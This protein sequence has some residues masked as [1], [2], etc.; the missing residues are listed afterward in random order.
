M[1]TAVFLINPRHPARFTGLFPKQRLIIVLGQSGQLLQKGAPER[2]PGGKGRLAGLGYPAIPGAHILADV[3]AKDQIPVAATQLLGNIFFYFDRQVGDAAAAVHDVGFHNGLGRALVQ[4]AAAASAVIAPRCIRVEFPVEQ[5]LA[6][7]K[8]GAQLLARNQIGILADPSDPGA[9]R[10]V[11]VHHRPRVH[12]DP[13]RGAGT[14][15]LNRLHQSFQFAAQNLVVVVARCVAG[16][17]S[18]GRVVVGKGV[19]MIVVQRN[20]ENSPGTLQD[21]ARI[22]TF[23]H[24]PGHVLHFAVIIA[25]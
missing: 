24:T 14:E 2:F 18:R 13:A 21:Q 10:P 8:P 6:N 5:D 22:E 7:E 9:G 1:A 12:I 3:A 16:H 4:T 15:L 25:L 17:D 23:I 11:L 19:G 20:R